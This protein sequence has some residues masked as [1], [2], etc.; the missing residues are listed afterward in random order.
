MGFPVRKRL[1]H[2]A[3]PW[4]AEGSFFF[5]TINCQRRGGNVLC[6]AGIGDEVLR[7]ATYYQEHLLWHCRLVLLMPDHLHGVIAFP[8][9]PGIKKTIVGW[10]KYLNRLHKI[11]WQRDFFD[12]RLRNHWE[13]LEKIDYIEK[14]LVRLGLC[15][16]ATDWPWVYR[17]KDRLPPRLGY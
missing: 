4:V 16:R 14:N 11:S 2:E 10:K 12:H 9:T 6:P 13:E 3:P 1:P 8:R 15:E 17:P 5:V 7:A